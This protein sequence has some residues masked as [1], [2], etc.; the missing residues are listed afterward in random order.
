[1]VNTLWCSRET[2][3]CKYIRQLRWWFKSCRIGLT[4]SLPVSGRQCGRH[5]CAGLG[6][7]LLQVSLALE[8][9]GVD[10]VDIFGP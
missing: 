4:Q 9:F 8:A 7:Q 6:H 3:E 1:M 5:N 2:S 10:L